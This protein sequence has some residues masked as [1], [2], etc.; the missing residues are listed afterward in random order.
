MKTKLTLF[1]IG[2]LTFNSFGQVTFGVSTGLNL[3][4]AY[5]G[6]SFGRIQPYLGFQ[7]LGASISYEETGKQYDIN[8]N[9]QDYTNSIEYSVG[10]YMPTLGAKYYVIEKESLKGYLNGSFTMV[11]ASGKFREDGEVNDD[12]SETFSASGLFG[13]EL[14]FG[15]EYF[16]ND[17]FSLGG[18]FGLRMMRGKN[19]DSYDNDNVL[20]IDPSTGNMVPS[21]VTNTF[22]G[23]F[24][25][26]YS[27][28]GLNFYF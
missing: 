24:A 21:Q 5:I 1:I 9:I 14:G 16:F 20:V 19:I 18:E 3:N 4:A 2:L 8:G 28:I 25:P 23:T 15:V 22:K 10:L 6:Y 27:K 26:T 13:G 17:Q 12:L 7:Y 11:I